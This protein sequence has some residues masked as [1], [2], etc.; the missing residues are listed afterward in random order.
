MQ[1]IDLRG[2]E[3]FL[4]VCDTGGLTSAARSLDLTQAA[5]SQH[6]AKIERELGV[7]LVDRSIRPQQVTA[8]GHYLRQRTSK[9]SR[10]ASSRAN[11]KGRTGSSL[12]MGSTN[13]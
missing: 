4:A 7:Q 2:L 5:V 6:L 9:L 13:E 12:K 11:R 8:A 3:I 10:T 1:P